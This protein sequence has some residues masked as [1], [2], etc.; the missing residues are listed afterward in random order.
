MNQ[1]LAPSAG[2]GPAPMPNVGPTGINPK[3]WADAFL[4]RLG[5][6]QP[7]QNQ[8]QTGVDWAAAEGGNWHNTAWYNPLNTTL[9]TAGSSVLSGGG[10]AAAAGVQAYGS[11]QQGMDATIS[12]ILEPR[13]SQIV[14]DLRGN[15]PEAQTAADIGASPW[16]TPNFHPGSSPAPSSPGYGSSSGGV[17]TAGWHVPNPLNLP[18]D[19]S[20][21]VTK[22]II[23]GLGSF[24]TPLKT[25]VEDGF[26]VVFGLVVIVVALVLAAKAAVDPVLGKTSI[27]ATKPGGGSSGGSS[28]STSSSSPTH[29]DSVRT[30]RPAL[31]SGGIEDAEIIG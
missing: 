22:G 14:A 1:T 2:A 30:D 24:A 26:L 16:G 27:L 12:T 8:E 11:W 21:Q 9:P 31:E 15:A 20:G 7:T 25:F 10:A 29:V 18:G 19:I 23:S 6:T 13:Y 5:I 4:A 17:S 3:Q 28:S